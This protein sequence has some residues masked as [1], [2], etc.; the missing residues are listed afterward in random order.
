M[1]RASDASA[2]LS[3]AIDHRAIATE[4]LKQE[5]VTTEQGLHPSSRLSAIGHRADKGTLLHLAAILLESAPPAWLFV[6]VQSSSVSRELIPHPDL[7]KLSWLEPQLDSVLISVRGRI[8]A[9]ADRSRE[10]GIG[11]AAELVALE[12]LRADHRLPTLVSDTAAFLGYDIECDRGDTAY[13]EIKGCTSR[14]RETFHLSRNEYDVARVSKANWKLLQVEFRSSILLT[15]RISELDVAGLRV[16]TAKSIE[17]IAPAETDSF[18]WEESALFRPAADSWQIWNAGRQMRFS[19]P[20]LTS[21]ASDA[22]AI[23]ERQ[24]QSLR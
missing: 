1:R 19:L 11:R 7:Q 24:S 8:G 10:L 2:F 13:W 15:S 23:H 6:A 9:K 3:G 4:L 21:L 12:I 14:T 5:L 22:A 20:A 18:R 16:A 17:S